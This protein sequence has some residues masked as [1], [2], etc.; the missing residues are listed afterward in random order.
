M[1]AAEAS[2]TGS[3]TTTG[4]PYGCPTYTGGPP[5][6]TGGGP[7]YGTPTPNWTIE[8]PL[9]TPIN[10]MARNTKMK[11]IMARNPAASADILYLVPSR[12]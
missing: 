5:N 7:K 12:M 11:T 1:L 6:T 2:T 4:T 9:T 10:V 8:D 3:P